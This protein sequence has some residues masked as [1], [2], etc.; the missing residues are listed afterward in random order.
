MTTGQLEYRDYCASCHGLSGKG[1][2]PVAGAL[3]KAPG[4]LTLLSRKHGGKFPARHVYR[5]IDG[6]DLIPSHDA[7]EMP[8]WGQVFR[9]RQG[10]LS[11]SGGPP[12][13]DQEI[14]ARINPLVEYVR[15]LQ[16]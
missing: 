12:L 1:D 5:T 2:G 10:C 4:D 16:E 11:G 14:K 7:R 13:T 3:S 6:R 15:S 8:V 9:L